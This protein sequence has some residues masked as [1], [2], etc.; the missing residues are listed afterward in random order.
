MPHGVTSTRWAGTH[1]RLTADSRPSDGGLAYER[2]DSVS[3]IVDSRRHD[4][5]HQQL[6]QDVVD[7]DVEDMTVI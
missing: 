2:V 3:S 4:D 7:V 1:G 6:Y 5:L